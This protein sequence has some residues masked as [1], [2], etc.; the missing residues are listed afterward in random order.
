MYRSPPVR[1]LQRVRPLLLTTPCGHVAI[2]LDV[3]I[4]R[5]LTFAFASQ[6][7]HHFRLHCSLLKLAPHISVHHGTHTACRVQCER[8][9][10]QQHVRTLIFKCG[11]HMQVQARAQ[12]LL[13]PVQGS[14]NLKQQQSLIAVKGPPKGMMMT[15]RAPLKCSNPQTSEK[16]I[17]RWAVDTFVHPVVLTPV[18]TLGQPWAAPPAPTNPNGLPYAVQM[19]PQGQHQ[20]LPLCHARLCYH[21]VE[22][23]SVG[24]QSFDKANKHQ[25]YVR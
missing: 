13:K 23:C 4:L 18:L 9:M 12:G 7:D 11:V 16:C 20:H 14:V 2:R 8:C 24:V 10:Q 19:L 25:E 3:N 17:T 5:L 22:A 1:S 15:F 6:F 21:Y